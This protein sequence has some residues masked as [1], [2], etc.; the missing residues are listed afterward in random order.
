MNLVCQICV[1]CNNPDE[2]TGYAG[3]GQALCIINFV[4]RLNVNGLKLVFY[5]VDCMNLGQHQNKPIVSF[6]IKLF[7]TQK[8]PCLHF[9][10]KRS[11]PCKVFDKYIVYSC[12]NTGLQQIQKIK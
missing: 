7:S 1:L 11:Y 12:K 9:F 3:P 8:G 4:G 10:K 2:L 6:T 5:C